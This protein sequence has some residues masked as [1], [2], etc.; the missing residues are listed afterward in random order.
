MY[1]GM[2]VWMYGWMDG[3]ME[4]GR[5]VLFCVT[6]DRRSSINSPSILAK[7]PEKK[8]QCTLLY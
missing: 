6:Y 3:W 8:S 1:V 2:Y 5:E 7:V 4:G